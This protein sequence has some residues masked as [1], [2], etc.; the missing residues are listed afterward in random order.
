MDGVRLS[1]R[2]VARCYATTV[3]GVLSLGLPTL[4]SGIK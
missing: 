1:G 2:R 3:T 4:A